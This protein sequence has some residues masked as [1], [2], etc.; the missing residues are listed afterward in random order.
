MLLSL[1]LGDP[2]Q[3]DAAVQSLKES[4]NLYDQIDL[5]QYLASCKNL[6]HFIPD[7]DATMRNLLEEVYL[8]SRRLQYWSV[9]RQASGL[10]AKTMPT[11]TNNLTDLVI[12]QKQVSI[13][14]GSNEQL[15]STPLNPDALTKIINERC[16]DDVREGPMVQ[17]III[18]LGNFIR[19]IPHMFDG[20]LRLRT[21]YIIIAL[22]EEISR[23]NHLDE[24]EAIEHLMQLSPFELHSLLGS[25]LSSPGMCNDSAIMIRD[26][27][28]GLLILSKDFDPSRQLS[29]EV[30]S[31][32]LPPPKNTGQDGTSILVRAQSG[33]YNAGNFARTEVNGNVLPA[34]TRGLHIWAISK[35]H[36]LVLEHASFDTH[37]STEES[38]ELAQFIRKLPSGLI[39]VMASKDDFTEHLTQRAIDAIKSLGSKLIDS[40]KYRDSYVLIAE[41]DSPEDA[42]EAHKPAN[43]GPTELI[44]RQFAIVDKDDITPSD[45]TQDNVGHFFPTSNGR[46]LRRRKNDG[47]LNRVPANFFPRT[48]SVLDQCHGFKIGNHC[49]PRDPTVFEKTPEEFNF[50]LAVE[51]FLGFFKDPAERQL[52]IEVLTLIYDV[53]QV[54]GP[55]FIDCTIDIPAI[56]DAAVVEFWTKW[57]SQNKETFEKSPFFKHGLEY[58]ANKDLARHLFYDLPLDDA[59]ESTSGYLSKSIQHILFNK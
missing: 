23:V 21:H 52:A 54:S 50:A 28:G 46:W 20:I 22:R 16:S 43:G 51:G 38:D 59:E 33:G 4:V 32:T 5:L 53:Q 56:A 27:P 37:I 10:L 25:V 6:D 30:P 24:E 7:L 31:L 42:I 49:L 39:V 58:P 57:V 55:H 11:L 15:I 34:N 40:I 12:R 36:K 1:T 26:R 48:W 13:G 17:E 41:K 18:S 29:I 14:S 19:T 44:E 8:K 3:F 35:D 45:I 9:A 2:S 47:A